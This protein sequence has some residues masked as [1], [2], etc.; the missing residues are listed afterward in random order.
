MRGVYLASFAG[1]VLLAA[2]ALAQAPAAGKLPAAMIPLPERTIVKPVLDCAALAKLEVTDIPGAPVRILSA[3]LNS[4]TPENCI[5][6][7]YVAPQ[8]QFELRLPT[9]TYTGRY[10]QLGCGGN[11]GTV[12]FFASPRCTAAVA[13]G[14]AFAVAASNAGHLGANPGDGIWAYND[15]QLRID[16]GYRGPH[17]TSQAAKA[18]VTA[19]YGEAPRYS[20][21]DGCSDGGREGLQEAQRYPADFNGIV[22]GSP[23]L[24]ITEA[25]E[26]FM[27]EA[28]NGLDAQG[29]EVLPPEKLSL[30][31]NAV[32]SACDGRDGLVDGE[33]DD[34][35]ACQY[36][37]AK[38]LCSG[39]QEQSSCLSAHQVEVARK[40]YAGPS[41][42]DGQKLYPGGEPYG[43]ELTWAGNGSFTRSGTNLANEFLKYMVYGD[44]KPPS[45]SWKDWKFTI[46]DLNS[47]KEGARIYDANNPDLIG[48][49]DAG[50]KLIVWQ[51]WA[52]NAAGA[53][54]TLDYY[55][56]VQNRMGGL[57]AT[58]KFARVFM[59]PGVY[60]CGGGY[61]AYEEDLLGAM[62]SWV[63][64]GKAPDQVIATAQMQDGKL[65]TRPVYAYP[66]RARYKGAGDT[67]DARN[68]EGAMP[69][70]PPNDAY[71]WVGA[72]THRSL[73]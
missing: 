7:G 22:A 24:M 45:F 50:G 28:R 73:R 64:S 60:H 46:D 36:D 55:Q 66:M 72:L 35:R 57:A 26:R 5:V 3:K 42:A 30:L 25:M 61:L 23:A 48:L 13:L 31:H 15:P 12:S 39:S 9:Q 69:S 71:P 4:A 56:A 11:C 40:F 29:N 54:G 62:V 41:T 44:Q 32:I 65:R 38:L 1:L 47:L 49:R 19:Y 18:I 51:G 27:W 68:F 21:F 59:V 34:P 37:P 20:Y 6:T 43:S 10:L 67:N 53:Y 8:V 2:P 63:E 70:P 33:I 52:D 58:L 16:F 17:V 14:G